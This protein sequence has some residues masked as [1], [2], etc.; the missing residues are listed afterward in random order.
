LLTK[1]RT[2]VL[3]VVLAVSLIGAGSVAMSA[4]SSN[5]AAAELT[6]AEL[7]I[8]NKVARFEAAGT[9]PSDPGLVKELSGWPSN[10]RQVTYLVTDRASTANW[11]GLATSE[12]DRPVIV[13]Q[14]RG[15]FGV[16]TTGPSAT[17]ADG[18]PLAAANTTATGSQELAVVDAA[19]GE[20]LDFS[21]NDSDLQLPGGVVIYS[22]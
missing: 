21:V 1:G 4:A 18:K 17:G 2:G 15:S 13:V 22:H 11:V 6:P 5:T 3:G 9:T 12:D 19:T 20:V 16:M 14:L 8:A 10:V 7:Q